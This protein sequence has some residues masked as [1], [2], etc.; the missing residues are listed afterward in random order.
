MRKIISFLLT[1][2][3]LINIMSLNIFADRVYNNDDEYIG[4][5]I[6][7]RLVEN[8]QIRYNICRLDDE[9]NVVKK[10]SE[11]YK[12]K[13]YS[14]YLSAKGFW[15]EIGCKVEWNP[16]NKSITFQMRNNEITMTAEESIVHIK[17]PLG[18]KDIETGKKAFIKD[19][20]FL[21]S[22]EMIDHF[23]YCYDDKKTN[24]NFFRE[25]EV[26]IDT[27]D[28]YIIA[29][30]GDSPYSLNLNLAEY[31]SNII[32]DELDEFDVRNEYYRFFY[33][34]YYSELSEEDKDK[35]ILVDYTN[36][37]MEIYIGEPYYTWIKTG[38]YRG[39]ENG[40][41]Q[42]SYIS[43]VYIMLDNGNYERHTYLMESVP[44]GSIN[45]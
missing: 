37:G 24:Y 23:I 32:K 40:R 4:L 45:K 18:E 19:G 26:N 36:N 17:N 42:E 35:L 29:Q 11:K 28:T 38:N 30:Y 2:I 22:V 10:N 41:I 33:T 39:I 21:I 1:V 9:R 14:Y 15:E 12:N 8:A 20:R 13:E 3:I 5:C 34:S 16:V 31:S 44:N 7:K 6:N 43:Y 25:K 27:K